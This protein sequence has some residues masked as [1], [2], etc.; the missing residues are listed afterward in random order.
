MY[1]D[2]QAAKVHNIS[3]SCTDEEIFIRL[4]IDNE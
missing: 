2:N 3:Q 4:S 1:S